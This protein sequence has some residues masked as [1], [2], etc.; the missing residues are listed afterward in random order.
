MRKKNNPKILLSFN[1]FLNILRVLLWRKK[2]SKFDNGRRAI[3]NSG[4]H[5]TSGLL[6][7]VKENWFPH[8]LEKEKKSLWYPRCHISAYPQAFCLSISQGETTAH[9]QMDS[10]VWQTSRLIH[11]RTKAGKY[12]V[13]GSWRSSRP[14]QP[15]TALLVLHSWWAHHIWVH[16]HAAQHGLGGLS[17][18]ALSLRGG[19]LGVYNCRPRTE[20]Q[21][22]GWRRNCAKW[23]PDSCSFVAVWQPSLMIM[24]MCNSTLFS[25]SF[26]RAQRGMWRCKNPHV[27][28]FSMSP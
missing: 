21:E 10:T 1:I 16:G 5:S 19:S 20:G 4:L 15:W 17:W 24:W 18:T 9:W 13:C 27:S 6:L 11:P 25:R 12:F 3:C 23:T 14:P 28:V 22:Q 2:L 26:R 8:F 7:P